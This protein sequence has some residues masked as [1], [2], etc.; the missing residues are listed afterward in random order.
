VEEQVPNPIPLFRINL[1]EMPE[2]FDALL[3]AENFLD[4]TNLLVTSLDHVDGD[5]KSVEGLADIREVIKKRSEVGRI[6]E[7]FKVQKRIP[8]G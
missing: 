5:L 2:K 8:M 6:S 3:A 4:A 1:R 7:R